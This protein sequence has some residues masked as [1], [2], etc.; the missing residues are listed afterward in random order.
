MSPAAQAAL[1]KLSAA[2]AASSLPAYALWFV[3]LLPIFAVSWVILIYGVPML[4]GKLFR[5][6]TRVVTV[7]ATMWSVAA[8]NAWIFPQI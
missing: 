8:V 3:A 5:N 1:D 4:S 2:W 7:M 6:T